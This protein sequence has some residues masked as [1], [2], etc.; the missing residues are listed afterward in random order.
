MRIFLRL[1][2]VIFFFF[3]RGVRVSPS[4]CPQPSSSYAIIFVS[5]G[6]DSLTQSTRHRRPLNDADVITSAQLNQQEI[7]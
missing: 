6:L 1:L 2:L 4:I 7:T 3:E 5:A